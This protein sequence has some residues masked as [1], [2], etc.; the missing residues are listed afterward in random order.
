MTKYYNKKFIFKTSRVIAMM[1]KENKL[2]K[3]L[4]EARR[5]KDVHDDNPGYAS[6]KSF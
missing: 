4:E 5:K 2:T 1:R 3:E 6:I